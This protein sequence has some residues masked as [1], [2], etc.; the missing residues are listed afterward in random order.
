MKFNTIV[1]VIMKQSDKIVDHMLQNR[2]VEISA[3]VLHQLQVILE[4]NQFDDIHQN[5]VRYIFLS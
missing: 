5:Q 2:N 4:T 1:Y 3:Y